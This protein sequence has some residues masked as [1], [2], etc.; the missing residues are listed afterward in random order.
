VCFEV[1]PA[2]D[3]DG[4]SLPKGTRILTRG[5][6]DVIVVDPSTLNDAALEDEVVFESMHSVTLHSARNKISFYTWSENECCLNAGA[7]SATLLDEPA[8]GLGKGDLLVFEEIVSPTTGAEED[9]D[10]AK[11]VALRLTET[12]SG[13]DP[14]TG[15][16]ILE[17]EWHAEDALP[18]PL[19]LSTR[20]GGISTAAAFE[21][22]VARGN[23]VLTDHGLTVSDAELTPGAPDEDTVFRPVLSKSNVT[24]LADYTHSIA[25]K[26]PASRTLVQDPR[27]ALAAVQ[28]TNDLDVWKPMRDLLATGRFDTRFVVETKNDGCAFLRFGDDVHGKEPAVGA[29]FDVS[30]RIGNG[31]GGNVGA[32]TL[33]RVVWD[34]NNVSRVRN[35]LAA[36]GGVPAESLAEVREFSPQAFRKQERAV[37]E[38]DWEEFAQKFEGVQKARARFRWTGS[39]Y[40]VFLT[41]DRVGGLAIDADETFEPQLREHLQ[42]YR[43]TGYDLEINNPVYVSLDI[44]LTVCVSPDH[45]RSDVHTEL[46]K[47]FSRFQTADGQ[48]GFFHPDNFTFGQP[49]YLSQ[50]YEAAMAVEGID[51]VEITKFQ[52]WGELDNNELDDAVLQ[53]AELEILRLDNDPSFQEHGLIEFDLKGGV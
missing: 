47:A 43:L 8:L 53:P 16:Q 1:N 40:T 7:T 42:R 36:V 46:L 2:G 24:F 51:S 35:P 9:S 4:Q 30:M 15:R 27:E 12:K 34:R 32:D 38:A 11:R 17:I 49:L 52:R 20:P 31:Q 10:P 18:F 48:R 29:N 6:D 5:S 44:S 25:V 23:I 26:V 45:F 50:V 41:V 21:V 19:C 33:T 3:A 37:T 14:I 22:S 39:W 28:L 13:K